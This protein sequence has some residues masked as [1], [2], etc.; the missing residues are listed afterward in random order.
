M[1][2]HVRIGAVIQ[3]KL[4]NRHVIVPSQCLV[5]CGIPPPRHVIRISASFEQQLDA[6][7]VVPVGLA[8]QHRRKAVGGQLAGLDEELQG[9]IV[10][11]FRRVIDD[12]PV[13]RV[14]TSLEKQTT[15]RRIVCDSS[16]TIESAFELVTLMIARI[17]S[18][19]RTRTGV[20][21]GLSRPDEAGCSRA[22]EPE[23]SRETE[24]GQCIPMT[25]SALRGRIPA[26]ELHEPAD[27]GIVAEYGCGI[28]RTRRELRMRGQNRLS[29]FEGSRGVPGIQRHTGGLNECN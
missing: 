19:V 16:C 10:V 6:I 24:V 7:V 18:G 25:R 9:L 13:V 20:E 2:L 23:I 15:E 8:K 26:V 5:E 4:D 12:F 29:T 28:D 21:Q 17:E 27:R 14:G 11:G 22:I 3:Q 1:C